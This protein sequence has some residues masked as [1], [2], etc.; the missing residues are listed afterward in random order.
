MAR[1][2]FFKGLSMARIYLIGSRGSGKT[3]VGRKLAR[4]LNFDFC[5]LDAYL[6][7][8]EGCSIARIV[9]RDGW[10]RFRELESAALAEA[11]W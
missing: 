4:A 9:E 7:E 11:G 5:D 2:I 8:R 1:G 6:C 10:Q 3:T